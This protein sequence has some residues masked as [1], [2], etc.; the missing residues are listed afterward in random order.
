MVHRIKSFPKV[1][2]NSKGVFFSSKIG[3]NFIDE[4]DE[5]MK[6]RMSFPETKLVITK[7]FM[8]IEEFGISMWPI[9]QIYSIVAAQWHCFYCLF[10]INLRLEIFVVICVVLFIA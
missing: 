3:C 6:G 5:G 1:T 7:D 9:G 4:M 2:E 10:L 8:N